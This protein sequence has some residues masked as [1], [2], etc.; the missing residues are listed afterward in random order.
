MQFFCFEKSKNI[1]KYK[2]P[3]Y[4]PL[5]HNM[6]IS[7][8]PQILIGI[9][10]GI[11][12]LSTKG[13]KNTTTND[14]TILYNVS[15]EPQ[16]FEVNLGRWA[17][18]SSITTL[19]SKNT[20]NDLGSGARVYPRVI[21]NTFQ[22]TNYLLDSTAES[23]PQDII[24]LLS[25]DP[26]AAVNLPIGIHNIVIDTGTNAPLKNFALKS[27]GAETHVT[28]DISDDAIKTDTWNTLYTNIVF[29]PSTPLNVQLNN[30]TARYIRISFDTTKTG[31]VGCLY[32]GSNK[33]KFTGKIIPNSTDSKTTNTEQPNT[34]AIEKILYISGGELKDVTHIYDGDFRTE[35][36]FNPNEPAIVIFETKTTKNDIQNIGILMG[37]H[38]GGSIDVYATDNLPILENTKQ[39]QLSKEN[40]VYL[41]KNFAKTHNPVITLTINEDG[42]ASGRLNTP[43]NPH[44]LIL[45]VKPNTIT[46]A[47]TQV[48][49][50]A[51]NDPQS[52]S[53]AESYFGPTENLTDQN[54]RS[55]LLQNSLARRQTIK[56]NSIAPRIIP[57]ATTVTP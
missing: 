13:Q 3:P 47:K 52:I 38:N 6:K 27:F 22:D 56:P 37:N 43:I 31:P 28:I 35:Y 48:K 23:S 46:P 41:E 42:R 55:L 21:N 50:G 26:T 11:T 25:E 54:N 36:A 34:N 16:T 14:S 20:E 19:P 44:Y 10:I 45:H 40:L 24:A 17:N 57:A 30:Q 1:F 49:K 18:G 39:T 7:R 53:I 4:N 9:L 32:I 51:P 29:N 8:F 2:R 33:T 12:P 15:N 5:L